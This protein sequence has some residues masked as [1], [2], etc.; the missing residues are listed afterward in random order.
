MSS[1]SKTRKLNQKLS[2]KGIL[3]QLA[4]KVMQLDQ[5]H[6]LEVI[7]KKTFLILK[8]DPATKTLL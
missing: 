5:E 7:V 3:K 2:M 4:I 8:A 1:D 6:Q